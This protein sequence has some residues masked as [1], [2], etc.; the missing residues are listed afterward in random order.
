MARILPA[1]TA[2]LAVL[3][4]GV[5]HGFWTDRWGI[6]GKPAEAAGRLEQ[7]ATALEDWESRDLELD[8]RQLGPVSGYL[9]RRYVNRRT[10]D[11]VTLFIICGRPG[12]VSIH[13]PDVC[14]SASGYE[15][16]TPIKYAVSAEG[17]SLAGEFW[18]AQLQKRKTT[19]QMH[20][21]I[22]WAWNAEGNWMAVSNPRLT[23]ARRPFLYKLYLLREL[24]TPDQPLEGDPCVEFMRLL[25]PELRR[26]LFPEA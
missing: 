25:L 23:F 6:S 5:V 4:C 13:T 7:V 22:F 1:T 3:V 20:L 24:S 2:V 9:H 26:A 12:P 19:E 11:A 18:T 21:R 15:V 16:A 10:G 17:S 14:Y 8:Q